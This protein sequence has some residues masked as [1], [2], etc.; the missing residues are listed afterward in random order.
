MV[1]LRR[2]I[3]VVDEGVKVREECVKK[4]NGRFGRGC[5]ENGEEKR[6]GG[7]EVK[8]RID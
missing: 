6:V 1:K 7:M 4:R 3:I 8:K 2:G 5:V